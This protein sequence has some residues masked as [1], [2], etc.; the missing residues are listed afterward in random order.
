MAHIPPA[1]SMEDPTKEDTL[2]AMQMEALGSKCQEYL[3][4]TDFKDN[5][6][7]YPLSRRFGSIHQFW[8]LCLTELIFLRK[9]ARN[10]NHMSFYLR[11]LSGRATSLSDISTVHFESQRLVNRSSI[12]KGEK[13]KL[14]GWN[15]KAVHINYCRIRASHNQDTW[16]Y[17]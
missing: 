5:S 17:L 7:N 8:N 13:S 11:L 14:G 6:S 3:S 12:S 2:R 9:L 16:T 1:T 4:T 15:S 10:T